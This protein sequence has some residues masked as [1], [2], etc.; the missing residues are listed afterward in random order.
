MPCHVVQCGID[1]LVEWVFEQKDL[2]EVVLVAV[3]FYS[4][5]QN[6]HSVNIW[7]TSSYVRRSISDWSIQLVVLAIT[8]GEWDDQVSSNQTSMD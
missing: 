7:F 2:E 8:L 5:K 4:G 1:P 3:F 6:V